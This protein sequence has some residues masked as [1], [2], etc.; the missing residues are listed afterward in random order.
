M[1]RIASRYEWFDLLALEPATVR[2]QQ[3]YNRSL[4]Y[5][6]QGLLPWKFDHWFRD[7]AKPRED[8]RN[9]LKRKT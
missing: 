8:P 9:F 1:D 4:Q 3:V 7:C 2:L 6:G 5:R